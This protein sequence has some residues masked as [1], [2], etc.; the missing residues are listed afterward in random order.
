MTG[1]G[2]TA[3]CSMEGYF[4]VTSPLYSLILIEIARALRQY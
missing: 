4:Q 1:A 3:I 2:D